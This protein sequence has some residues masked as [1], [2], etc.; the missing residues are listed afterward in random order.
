MHISSFFLSLVFDFRI[1]EKLVAL[2][3]HSSFRRVATSMVRRISVLT[4][5]GSQFSQVDRKLGANTDS[6][7][8][9]YGNMA[10]LSNWNDCHVTRL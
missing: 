4:S 6:L 9:Q 1:E 5:S 3:I 7:L 2:L 8:I 10:Q